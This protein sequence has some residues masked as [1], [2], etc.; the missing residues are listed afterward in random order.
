MVMAGTARLAR[1][2]RWRWSPR[3]LEPPCAPYTRPRTMPRRTNTFQQ[4]VAIVE[5]HMADGATVEESAMVTPIRG[6]DPREVDVL[7]SA[8]AGGHEV[9]GGVEACRWARK[10]DVGWV[11]R[12]KAK[13]DDLPTNKLVLYSGSGFTKNALAK[14]MAL[15]RSAPRSC[16]TTSWSDAS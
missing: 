4:V 6:G 9:L 7:V 10:A 14:A 2:G 8:K 15:S 3:Y 1:Y 5:R 12:M 13:H 11:E 16:P